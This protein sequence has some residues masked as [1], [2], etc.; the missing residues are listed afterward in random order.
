[1]IGINLGSDIPPDGLPA[2]S[3]LVEG[4]GFDS[5][6][7]GEDVPFTAGVA[8]AT[9][10]LAA[11]QAI[12]V[13]SAIFSALLRQPTILAME[14]ATMARM[15]P[16]R[17]LVCGIGLGVPDWL[18]QL[19]SYRRS[20]LTAV[21][22]S[23]EAVRALLDG[24]RLEHEGEHFSFDGIQLVHPPDRRIPIFLGSIGEKMLELAGEIGDGTFLS[25][26]A[27]PQYVAWARSQIAEGAA[28]S[29]RD[30]GDHH[31]SVLAIF[32]IS[33]DGTKTRELI[34]ST[35]AWWIA[36]MGANALT[37]AYGIAPQVRD[38]ITRSGPGVDDR[39][40]TI[41]HEMPEQ[42]LRDL[43]VAG[44][45]DECAD[46]INHLFEA[47]ADA[48]VLLPFPAADAEGIIR[49]AARDVLPRVRSE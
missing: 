1:M 27:S 34:R 4:L 48:V 8:A 6:V 43:V 21:R 29:G 19:H 23:V 41:A 46:A 14:I 36:T 25:V 31:I 22:E 3:A 33:S 9:A 40:R 37:E 10:S 5:L 47:G 38:M 42:W 2:M 32:S 12:P 17:E 18:R 35:T 39:A 28:R 30:S 24:K 13:Q 44:D 45:P 20:P 11:T 26:V 16:G 7:V 49:A 15:Y